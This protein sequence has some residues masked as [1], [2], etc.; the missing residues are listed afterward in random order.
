MVMSFRNISKEALV[1]S[2]TLGAVFVA[3]YV[4]GK[5]EHLRCDFKAL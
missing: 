2:I 3:G 1:G 4:F 5:N